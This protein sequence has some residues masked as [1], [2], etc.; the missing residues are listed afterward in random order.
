MFFC[1]GPVFVVSAQQIE[2]SSSGQQVQIAPQT[3]EN[4]RRKIS[5]SRNS[6]LKKRWQNLDLTHKKTYQDVSV[7]ADL[8]ELDQKE[9]FQK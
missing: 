9:L 8:M 3:I 1:C 4:L 5:N 6:Q 7:L 2:K